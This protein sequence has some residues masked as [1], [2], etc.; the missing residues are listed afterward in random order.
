MAT[1]DGLDTEEIRSL[2]SNIST[3]REIVR[4]LG[5]VGISALKLAELT[6]VTE[7]AVRNWS[8]GQAQPKANAG[9]VIEDLRTAAWTLLGTLDAERVASW[10]TRR[11]P[12][13]RDRPI[14]RI[15]ANPTQVID[16]AFDEAQLLVSAL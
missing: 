11:H 3:T 12:D 15:V 10:F 14:D 2:L 6:G 1:A 13:I 8:S 16:L 7:S 9:I 5:H 4:G